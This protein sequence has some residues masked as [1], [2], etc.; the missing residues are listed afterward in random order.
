[1]TGCLEPGWGNG[2]IT[3]RIVSWRY[4]LD[5]LVGEAT[6]QTFMGPCAHRS[7]PPRT[8]AMPS[9]SGEFETTTCFKNLSQLRAWVWETQVRIGKSVARTGGAPEQ[10]A[11]RR[12]P[13]TSGGI[14]VL[15]PYCLRF[16]GKA[17]HLAVHQRQV[18]LAVCRR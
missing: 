1:L 11:S 4:Q 16:R 3:Y 17:K 6:P 13:A 18:Q 10:V 5:K 7:R 12:F 8:L 15:S 9:Y 2:G 14:R